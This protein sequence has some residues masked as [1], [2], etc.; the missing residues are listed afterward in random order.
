MT[1]ATILIAFSAAA[2]W[3]LA[4]YAARKLGEARLR[5]ARRRER[6]IVLTYDDG[7]GETLTDSLLEELRRQG[8]RATFFMRG[9]RVDERPSEAARVL[10]AGHEV[11]HH[12]HRHLNPWKSLPQAAHR[13][14]VEGARRIAAL[15]GDAHLHRPPFGKL[16]LAGFIAARRRG[17]RLAWWT[18]DGQDSLETRLPAEEVLALIDRQ[19]GGVVLLHDFDAYRLPGHAAHVL[20]LTRRIIDHARAKGYRIMTFGELTTQA[21]VQ[22]SPAPSSAVALKRGS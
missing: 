7:P 12:S 19:Q 22:P 1:W 8:A 3:F 16:T 20:D 10:A 5:Q 18:V 4:P 13:D 11:G 15:G 17:D 9:D 6:A 2:A 21:G 14:Y